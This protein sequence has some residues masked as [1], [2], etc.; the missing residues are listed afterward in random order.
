MRN[1]LFFPSVM[2][3]RP[4]FFYT[5]IGYVWLNGTVLDPHPIKMRDFTGNSWQR[6]ELPD[7]V[8]TGY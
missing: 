3:V 7:A 6:Y 5:L 1:P 8:P 2:D 4:V